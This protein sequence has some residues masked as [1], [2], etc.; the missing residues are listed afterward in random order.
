MVASGSLG[1]GAKAVK[2]KLKDKVEEAQ[3]VYETSQVNKTPGWFYLSHVVNY[4][5]YFFVAM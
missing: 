5:H 1:K 3:E 4:V 2:D